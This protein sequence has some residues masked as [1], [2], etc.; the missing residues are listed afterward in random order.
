[1]AEKIGGGLKMPR[2]SHAQ[3]NASAALEF[4]ENLAQKLPALACGHEGKVR[5]WVAGGHR[6]GLPPAVRRCRGLRGVRVIA[7]RRTKH[8]WG[9]L[10]EALEIDG[11][12]QSEF[13]F[14]PCARKEV[15]ARFLRQLCDGDPHALHI[16]IRD[17]AGFHQRDDDADVP[18]KARLLQLPPRSP[19]LNPVEGV[20]DAV[21]DTVC[22]RLY[23]TLPGLEE[24][25]TAGLRPLLDGAAAVRRRI[26]AWMRLQT[27]AS[28]P[29]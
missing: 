11:G 17:G 16:V 13:W 29:T 27:N 7:P 26:H 24:A 12:T 21:K 18:P 19:G 2:E 28:V 10:Y 23:D 4:R 3:K 22:N 14:M 15:G 1:L 25:I 5:L 20:G 9:H 8:Q 6:R